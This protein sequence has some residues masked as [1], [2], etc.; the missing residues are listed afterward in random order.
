MDNLEKTPSFQLLVLIT[1]PKLAEKATKI[2]RR[3]TLPVQYRLN[4]EGTA[5]SEIMDMLGLG[6]IDKCI[7]MSAVSRQQGSVMLARLRQELHLGAIN[8][9]IAFTISL[10]GINKLL[11]RILTKNE[12]ESSAHNIRKGGN[13]IS[14]TKYAL[15][16]A[17]VNIGFSGDVMDAARAA[18][19]SG[20]TVVH[21][22]W[23]GNEEVAAS[24]GLSMQE[25]KEIVL[26]LSDA[27]KKVE[28]M[29]GISEKCGMRSEAK[30]MV[31]S[32]PIDAVMGL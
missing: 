17:T 9:G 1:N 5:S 27:D 19:A 12:E 13:M 28:I 3:S 30:G 23:I 6:S 16:V 15:I 11:M 32:L 8:S 26:I 21:S 7:L 10:T 2:F 25:E 24:W 31:L 14:D 20:G 4:A 29:S 18:G 22:R